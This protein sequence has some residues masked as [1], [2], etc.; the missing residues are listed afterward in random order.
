MEL[1]GLGNS[2][3]MV[4][5]ASRYVSDCRYGLYF[6]SSCASSCDILFHVSW[7]MQDPTLKVQRSYVPASTMPV[8]LGLDGADPATYAT[9]ET[10]SGRPF[11][12]FPEDLDSTTLKGGISVFANPA[13]GAS[14][15]FVFFILSCRRG[16][17]DVSGSLT[18]ACASDPF[19]D[20]HGSFP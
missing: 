4:V 1:L 13:K 10:P 7:H 18:A 8:S 19:P 3:G 5:D 2:C 11:H 12:A 15:D 14:S 9:L 20:C 16:G 6:P 17:A